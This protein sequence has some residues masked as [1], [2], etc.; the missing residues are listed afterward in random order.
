MTANGQVIKL[1]GEYEQLTDSH[2]SITRCIKEMDRVTV[3]KF[4]TLANLKQWHSQLIRN[5][6]LASGRTDHAELKW[7][8]EIRSRTSTAPAACGSRPWT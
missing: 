8:D 2:E 3:P 7:L 1:E 6:V 5:L 4:P